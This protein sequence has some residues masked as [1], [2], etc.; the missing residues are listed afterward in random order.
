MKKQNALLALFSL[1]V[2]LFIT[3]C[4]K[5]EVPSSQY[6]NFAKCLTDNGAKMYGAYWCSHCNNQKEMF[7]GSVQYIDYTE[8]SLPDNSGQTQV[9]LN[10]NIQAYPT[11]E[12]KD[13]SRMQGELTLAQ[14]SQKSGCSLS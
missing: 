10:A 3:S 5:S 2:L 6:D 12:F 13:G 7:G 8:C 1:I 4:T 14:L 11:W 9:C